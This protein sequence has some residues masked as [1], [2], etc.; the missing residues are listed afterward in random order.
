MKTLTP[1]N[2]SEKILSFTSGRESVALE[3]DAERAQV[4]RNLT[5]WL[6]YRRWVIALAVTLQIAAYAPNIARQAFEHAR[7]EIYL[8]T[9]RQ[10]PAPPLKHR[11]PIDRAA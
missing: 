7:N 9:H 1:A 3:T 2:M 6:R 5:F 8:R 4:K 11:V 10:P